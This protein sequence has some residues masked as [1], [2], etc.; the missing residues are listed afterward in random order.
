[1]RRAQRVPTGRAEVRY[2]SLEDLIIHKVIAG[3]P[4]DLEDV[5]AL[6]LKNRSADEEYIRD[7]LAQ[8]ETALDQP[9]LQVFE[10][11]WRETSTQGGAG[12]ADWA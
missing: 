3:R 8:F 7:W 11:L 4:K 12:A 10:G 2:A 5:R 1:M 9:V 6:L